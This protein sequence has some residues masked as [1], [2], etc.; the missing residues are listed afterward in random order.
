MMQVV[1]GFLGLVIAAGT[2]A[3]M[4]WPMPTGHPITSLLTPHRASTKP[5][6]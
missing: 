3:A 5:V 6:S 2:F 4:H 1:L